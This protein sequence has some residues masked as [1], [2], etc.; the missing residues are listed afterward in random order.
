MRLI[1]HV[2]DAFGLELSIRAVFAA[3]TLEAMAAG[4]ERRV[5]EDI[6]EMSDTQAEELAALNHATEG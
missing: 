2:E 1:A 5:L 6:L 3:P 4:I